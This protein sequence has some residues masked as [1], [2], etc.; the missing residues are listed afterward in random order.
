MIGC[1]VRATRWRA[2][3]IVAAGLAGSQA[4]HLLVYRLRFGARAGALQSAGAH[5]YFPQLATTTLAV[6][7]MALVAALGVIGAARLL[8][9]RVRRLPAAGRPPFIE[10][11][12]ALFTL[13]LAVFG[14]QEA[15]ECA[16]AGARLEPALL[17]Y[18]AACQ[19]PVA[20]VG[21]GALS[22]FLTRF[23]RALERLAEL[24]RRPW[25]G[26]RPAERQAAE[27]LEALR[28]APQ[29]LLAGPA[30]RGPPASRI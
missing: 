7:G 11:A 1:A 25:A 4:G 8:G 9:G 19:L 24:S 17:L 18:G 13:Q 28:L 12:A 21:A 30:G 14:L 22:L 15:L 6:A 29:G 23:E 20:L 5:A 2:A 26:F 16:A 27:P 10:V 3:W